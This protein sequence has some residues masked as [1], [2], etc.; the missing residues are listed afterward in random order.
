MAVITEG[1][2]YGYAHDLTD[3]FPHHRTAEHGRCIG[4]P[5]ELATESK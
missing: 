2:G 1:R 4:W 3:G 5:D